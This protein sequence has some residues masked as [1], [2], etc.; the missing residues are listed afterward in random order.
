MPLANVTELTFAEH[1]WKSHGPL[2]K[3]DLY[4][5][6]QTSLNKSRMEIIQGKISDYSGL[7]QKS[8]AEI[9]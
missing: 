7:N 2:T 9:Y 6:A 1:L 5:Q 4:S 8:I 3:I